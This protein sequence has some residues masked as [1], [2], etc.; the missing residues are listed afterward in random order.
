[1]FVGDSLS[2]NMWESLGCM[3]HSWVPKSRYNFV[4][5]EGISQIAFPVSLSRVFCLV[6]DPFFLYFNYCELAI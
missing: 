2:L 1:M 4:R 5:T 6:L 3:L